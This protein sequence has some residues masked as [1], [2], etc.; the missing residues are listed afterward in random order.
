M[1]R[2]NLLGTL[3]I[4]KDGRL[5]VPTAPKVRGVLA[6]LLVRANHVVDI[7]SIIAE[8]WGVNPP[9]S[10]VT[11]TQT[12]VYH[13][14]RKF[15]REL[16]SDGAEMLCT[17]PPGY[18]LRVPEEN[19]DVVRFERLARQGRALLEEDRYE[20]A[21]RRLR[22][23]LALWRGAPLSNVPVGRLLEAHIAHLE[24]TRIRALELR[25]Q[26][27]NAL[28]RHREL[29]P[30]LRSLVAAYPLNEW[31]HGQLI[32]ALHR[33]GRRGEALRAY[34]NVRAVLGEE[35]GLEPSVEL[36]RLQR[37]V[38]TGGGVP[39]RERVPVRWSVPAGEVA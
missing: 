30:E 7:D 31:F 16:T 23:A 36:Q 2:F 15:E 35:L 26:A 32:G 8:L 27:D 33:A 34:Q 10:A 39:A 24:E 37:D 12:Y 18:V 13:L 5:S 3:E 19:L 14:R 22:E 4:I 28:G 17:A 9:R 20:E 21:A 29:I 1:S 38:L 11:T 6:L 25:I